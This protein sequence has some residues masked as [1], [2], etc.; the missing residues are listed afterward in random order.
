MYV[1]PLHDM[2]VDTHDVFI[3]NMISVTFVDA[4]DRQV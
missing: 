3:T 4:G 2:T 1:R